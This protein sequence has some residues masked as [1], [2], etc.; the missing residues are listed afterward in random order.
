MKLKIGKLVILLPIIQLSY[1]KMKEMRFKS[2]KVFVSKN[3]D[4]KIVCIID[5]LT[6]PFMYSFK[7][8]LRLMI[9]NFSLNIK[10]FSI[11]LN[12]R[13]FVLLLIDY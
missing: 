4:F 11:I 12:K 6:H 7:D 2:E 9:D 3:K 13:I 10:F 1:N 8:I 5:L